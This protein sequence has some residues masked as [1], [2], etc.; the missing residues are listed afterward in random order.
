MDKI[1]SF[2]TDAKKVKA[3]DALASVQDRDRGDLLNPAL[4]NYLDLRQYHTYLI[5]QGIRHAD[6]GQLVDHRDVER[7]VAKLRRKK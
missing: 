3:L 4:D 5:Q 6:A 7:I 2:R 1:V